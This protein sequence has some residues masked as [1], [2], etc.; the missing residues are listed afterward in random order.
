MKK[1][2]K[3]YQWRIYWVYTRRA[4]ARQLLVWDDRIYISNSSTVYDRNIYIGRRLD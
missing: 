1:A 2:K 4:K 3:N